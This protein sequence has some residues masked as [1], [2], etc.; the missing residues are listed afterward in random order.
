MITEEPWYSQL[1]ARWKPEHVKLLMIAESAP[2]DRGDLSNRRFFYADRLG[3]DNLFRGVV[4]AMYGVAKDDLKRTGKGPWLERLQSDG[5]F[6]IDLAPHPVNALTGQER[7]RSLIQSVP[8]CV[9][10]AAQLNPDG[11][12]VV[13][14]DLYPMLASPLRDAGL[15][16]LQDGPIAFP[17]GNTR[18]EFVAS[19]NRARGNLEA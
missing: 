14:A 12:V 15:T 9:A 8:N 11:V 13:K 2:D 18:A 16:L 17:L 7:R 4:E 19:F 3:A 10:R 5:F 6:L 1:R